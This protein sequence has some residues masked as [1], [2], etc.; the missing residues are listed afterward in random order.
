MPV[1]WSSRNYANRWTTT[2]KSQ[3]TL[4][5]LQN[6]IRMAT[7]ESDPWY[8]WSMAYPEL[9]LTP[10]T[11]AWSLPDLDNVEFTRLVRFRDSLSAQIQT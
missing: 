5:L 8:S 4:P 10:T 2:G 1:G 3:W 6:S 9:R 7:A 11:P